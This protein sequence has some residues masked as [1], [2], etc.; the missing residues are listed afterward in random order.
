MVFHCSI[1]RLICAHLAMAPEILFVTWQCGMRYIAVSLQVQHSGQILW[2]GYPHRCTWSVFQS[3]FC[4]TNHVKNL[5][6]EGPWLLDY[7]AKVHLSYSI[8]AFSNIK[9][10][11][12][13]T[14]SLPC[15]CHFLSLFPSIWLFM[16]QPTGSNF[17]INSC[18]L[19][20]RGFK[21]HIF[22]R[23]IIRNR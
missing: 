4:S 20:L 5:Y 17:Y 12:F 19:Q 14:L 7:R 22:L 16:S 11:F 18:R 15:P 10:S 8:E 13:P 1:C 9:A 6:L 2:L 3:L 21:F 23:N